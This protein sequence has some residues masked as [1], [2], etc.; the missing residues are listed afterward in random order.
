MLKMVISDYFTSIKRAVRETKGTE[1]APRF[2]LVGY[3]CFMVLLFGEEEYF[4][5]KGAQK[6]WS[7]FLYVLMIAAGIILGSLHSGRPGKIWYLLPVT[8]R[9]RKTFMLAGYWFR[10]LFAVSVVGIFIGAGIV[11][12]GV[13]ILRAALILWIFF[14]LMCIMNVWGDNLW[15][16]H[17]P[18][19][20]SVYAAAGTPQSI[21][22]FEQCCYLLSCADAVLGIL[23]EAQA[24][25]GRYMLHGKL[26]ALLAVIQAGL[27][28]VLC[29]LYFRRQNV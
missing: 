16:L 8:E 18:Q 9:E 2:A 27:T 22:R 28:A 29:I 12:A 17:R 4:L 11:F 24:V 15:G 20:V 13:P 3:Y 14:M 6:E 19:V 23:L 1:W 7:I 5:G 10:V 26:Y 21:S 25:S